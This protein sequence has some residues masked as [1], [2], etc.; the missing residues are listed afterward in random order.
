MLTNVTVPSAKSPSRRRRSGLELRF[1]VSAAHRNRW[2]A[3]GA[4]RKQGRSRITRCS[5]A[6]RVE[7]GHTVVKICGLSKDRRNQLNVSIGSDSFYG[8][9]MITE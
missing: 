9:V 1:G 3:V 7:L 6:W 2:S 4:T 8:A 5:T